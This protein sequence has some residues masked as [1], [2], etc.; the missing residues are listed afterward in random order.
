MPDSA[1]ALRHGD[2]I[3]SR[4]SWIAA[5][6]ALALLSVSYGAPLPV[7]VGL[8]PIQET[9]GADRS[10]VALAGA[11]I[12]VGT[13]LGGIGM[14]WLADRIGIRATIAFGAVMSA[15]GLILSSTGSIW[16][17]YVGHFLLIGLLGNAAFYAPL[18]IYVSRWFD[19]R[20]GTALALISSG[21]YIAGI[22]WPSIFERGI[23]RFGWQATMAG[24]AVVTVVLILPI[25][26]VG[27]SPAPEPV[28]ISLPQGP[29]REAASAL[30]LPLNVVQV[31]LCVASFLCCVPMALPA[32]HLV[33]FCSDLGIPA[34]QGAAMLSVMLGCAFV[35]RQFWGWFGDRFGGLRA[36]LAGSACQAAA[37]ACFLLTQNEAGL[38]A[39]AA[40]YGLGFSGIIPSY[41]LAVRELFPSSQAAWRV[42]TLLFT[43]MSGMA[44]GSWFG[45]AVYDHFGYYA[46][47]FGSGVVF[48]LGNLVV[49][50]LLVWRQ[51]RGE[52]EP[53]F[54]LR[55]A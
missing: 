29:R 36:V 27:L 13:G 53:A 43:G 31:L 40:A 19:R 24:F 48:N 50:G 1:P 55:R 32:A 28:A 44:F 7:V 33:A 9:L 37:I 2:S 42:P 34:T 21:Q 41:V 6:L 45:G 20:R 14:G 38:F 46:P 25:V 30:G 54:S 23:Q 49:I 10:V 4:R 8:K 51:Q 17:L 15:S 11:L 3:E 5:G 26:L 22:V 12:W 35:S 52:A 18:L 39:V 16:A 47:A